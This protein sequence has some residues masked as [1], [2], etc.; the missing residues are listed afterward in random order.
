[1][2]FQLLNSKLLYNKQLLTVSEMKRGPANN[3]WGLN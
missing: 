1:M 2:V 3:S